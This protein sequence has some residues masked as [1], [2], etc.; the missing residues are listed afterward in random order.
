MF[1]LNE[2]QKTLYPTDFDKIKL[3]ELEIGGET[4]AENGLWTVFRYKSEYFLLINDS[5]YTNT[6][7]LFND[8]SFKTL[9]K[10]LE[11]LLHF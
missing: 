6:H 5:E 3:Q 9:S 10:L 1:D 11:F 7:K 2:P 8:Y 4:R